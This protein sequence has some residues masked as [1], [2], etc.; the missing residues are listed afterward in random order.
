MATGILD[1]VR[2]SSKEVVHRARYVHLNKQNIP[3]FALS[4]IPELSQ[5]QV[6]D[7]LHHFIGS[8]EDTSAFILALDS[9]NFGSGYFPDLVKPEDLSGYYTIS[10]ALK[11]YFER[12]GSIPP[13]RLVDVT[14]VDCANIFGQDIRNNNPISE[15]MTLYAQALNDLGKFILDHFHGQ[16]L[17]LIIASDKSVE[18]LVELLIKM[19]FFKDEA[20]Y[21]DVVAY[22][23]KRA[24]I[25]A[26]DI[27]LAFRG[28]GLGDFGDLNR[29]TIFA[30]NAVPH[31]LRMDGIIEYED[32][33][34]SRIDS[35]ELLQPSS[36]EEI[37]IRAAAI[38]VSEQV[39]EYLNSI[40]HPI[41]A[42]EL[43]YVLWNKA[44]G[45]T[46]KNSP[47]HRTRTV[48]Y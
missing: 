28:Q 21:D 43:D 19:P 1:R 39:V 36:Y 30:D 4:L 7:S 48:F 24:Q 3:A 41:I 15:L 35:G 12:N 5:P 40:S 9:I 44:H 33:L 29:L 47:R 46:Y 31:V 11:N 42:R 8:L 23:Y 34:A 38:Y 25:T 14:A 16:Y 17:G 26:S 22:F 18:R 27:H 37:E 6:Y 10:T 45:P 13:E 32:Q 20:K 2:S